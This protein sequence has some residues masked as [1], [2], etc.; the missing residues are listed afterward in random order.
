MNH[1]REPA[2]KDA[3]SLEDEKQESGK[4]RRSAVPGGR[5][6]S[7]SPRGKTD[8]SPGRRVGKRKGWEKKS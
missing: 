8:K 5:S 1:P 7:A 4:E 6:A 3:G 2:K